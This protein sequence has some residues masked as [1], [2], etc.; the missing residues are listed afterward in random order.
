MFATLHNHLSV[1]QTA[2]CLACKMDSRLLGNEGSGSNLIS[3]PSNSLDSAKPFH[4]A[5]LKTRWYIEALQAKKQ[6]Q[7]WS[8]KKK[9]ALISGDW[10]KLSYLARRN[11]K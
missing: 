10:E 9:E 1:H 3:K 6:I 8:R 5:L 11:K 4:S 7:G 2:H